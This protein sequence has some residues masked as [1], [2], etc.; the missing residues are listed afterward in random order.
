MKREVAKVM[1]T[2]RDD[3][4]LGIEHIDK[5]HQQLFRIATDIHELIKNELITDKY[6]QILKLLGQLK[7]YTIFHFTSEEE[8]MMSIG[9]RKLL[10]HKVEHSDFIEKINN[11]DLNKIDMDH[12][13]YLIEILDFVV[14]WISDHILLTDRAYTVK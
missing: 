7:E 4:L 2:W 3:F 1:I 10:S 6:D 9:Y 5:Q 13:Q 11:V 8:Y 12:E 14:K